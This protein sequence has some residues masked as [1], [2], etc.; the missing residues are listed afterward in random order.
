MW[1]HEAGARSVMRVFAAI[2][3][4]AFVLVAYNVIFWLPGIDLPTRLVLFPM[5]SGALLEMTVADVLI[6]AALV[7]LFLET[8]KSTGAG[9]VTILDHILSTGVF[10][11]ALVEFLLVPEAGNPPFLILVIVCLMDVLAGYAVSLRAARRDVSVS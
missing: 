4:L 7:V 3:L 2:P 1:E 11:L 5:P 10:V 6:I 8:L 9:N